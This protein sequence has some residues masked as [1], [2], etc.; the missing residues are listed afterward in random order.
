MRYIKCTSFL[1]IERFSKLV[2]AISKTALKI[3]IV[4]RASLRLLY[5]CYSRA[6][7][8]NSLP[9]SAKEQRITVNQFKNILGSEYSF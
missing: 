6:L 5:K 1:N 9:S 8:W 3:F 2:N 4:F 7:L